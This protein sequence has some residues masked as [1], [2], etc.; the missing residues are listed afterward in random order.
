MLR[1][2]YTG[3][4]TG[5]FHDEIIAAGISH[6]AVLSENGATYLLFQGLRE[7]KTPVLDDQEEVIG[8]DVTYEKRTEVRTTDPETQEEVVTETWEPYDGEALKA[9]IQA[10]VDVHDPTPLPVPPTTEERVE[11]LEMDN[12]TALEGVALVYEENLALKSENEDLKAQVAQAE[13]DNLT[14]LEGIATLYE[15]LLTKGVI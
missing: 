15:E 12:L 2:E 11:N 9:S 8:Y 7:V 4:N 1:L 14:A 10:V 6:T 3:L 5:K 13:A